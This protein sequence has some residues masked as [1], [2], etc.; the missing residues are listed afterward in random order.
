VGTTIVIT[1]IHKPV[2]IKDLCW[3]IN[4]YG[5]DNVDILIIGDLK[6]PLIKDYC[7]NVSLEFNIPIQYLDIEAQE[8][9]LTDYKPLLDLFPYNTPD[10]VILGGVIAYLRGCERIIAV[11]DDN[12]VTN[13]DFVGFHSVAGQTK[14]MPVLQNDL[15][16]Y[17]VHSILKEERDIPFYPRGYPFSKR[18]L[19][20]SQGAYKPLIAKVVVNQGLVEGDPDI[21]ALTRL[22]NLI[23]V[24]GF[25]KG[26]II[27]FGLWKTWSPFN[28]QN[29]CLS[30]ELIPCYYRPPLGLR[31]ADI[32]TA[33]IFNKLAE[34]FGDI[35]T[36]GQPLVKQIRNEHNLFDDLKIELQN[37]I[38]T[39]YFV[40]MLQAVTLTKP[41][42]F[43]VL[44]E[45][46]NKV[47]I[48]DSHPMTKGFIEE[49][50]I[51][52]NVISEGACACT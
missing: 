35:I 28:Y 9:A 25:K 46:L 45:L 29:T 8:K 52:C 31:N 23:K 11:D 6:T 38:E 34:H 51:W 5:H 7:Q 37:N 13:A 12:F 36:F 39:D 15:G 41:N 4:L 50:K 47:E 2:F 24:E 42:Y 40:E 48:D 30:R 3:N 16:W 10:R 14:D 43:D 21:D 26:T 44:I 18:L 1:T 49:Y 17:N 33:Y 27:H 20:S 22:A 19:E 32:W